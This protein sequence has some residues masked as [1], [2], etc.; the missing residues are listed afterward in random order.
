MLG[1]IARNVVGDG[2]TVEVLLPIGADPHGFQ[3][4]SAQVASI[5][6]ADLVIAN[7]LGL[8]EGLSDVIEAATRDGVTAI[9]VAVLVDPVT[10]VHRQVC[11]LDAA[12]SCDPHVW[13]DPERD[14]LTA[15][16][17]GEQLALAD[18]S[19]DWEARAESYAVALRAS[20]A[21]IEDMLSVVPTQDR[22]LVTNHDSLGYFADRY[23]FEVIGSVIPRGSTVSEPSSAEIAAL[24]AV[25]NETGVSAIFAETT[26]PSSLADAIASEADHPVRVV[27]LFTGSLGPPGFG[28]DTLI[29]MLETNAKRVADGL[30]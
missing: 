13:L 22:I 25:I 29:G 2:G 4:S 8:E 21:V 16:I 19:V 1:D 12:L 26:E 17:I 24:V 5:Y 20:D 10:F 30:S 6:A 18:D 11:D 3:P 23:D 15:L 9:G 28:A 27:L 14:A 7:G